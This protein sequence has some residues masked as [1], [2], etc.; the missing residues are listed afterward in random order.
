PLLLDR[1][2]G[3]EPVDRVAIGLL[4]PLEEL[5]RVRRQRLDVSTL[6]LGIEGVEGER[7]L[8]RA[9]QAREHDQPLARDV[10]VDALQ[11]VGARAPDGDGPRP[12]HGPTRPAPPAPWR[13]PSRRCADIPPA[14]TGSPP[15]TASRAPAAYSRRGAAPS[16]SQT[17]PAHRRRR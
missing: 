14:R 16:P 11:I 9:R 5:A 10:D 6:A 17:G 12:V 15:R 8:A 13:R 7:R 2:R 4:H 1:D 3:G